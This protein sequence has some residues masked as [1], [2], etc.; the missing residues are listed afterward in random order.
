MKRRDPLA[1][2]V[3]E[4]KNSR[5]KARKQPNQKINSS[6]ANK[7]APIEPKID[8]R[9]FNRGHPGKAG[10]KPSAELKTI[11]D[12]KAKILEHGLEDV[13]VKGENGAKIVRK[14]R[15]LA[16]LDMLY[17]EA[18]KNKNIS[19]AR[20][21]IDRNL[22]KAAQPIKGDDETPLTIKVLDFSS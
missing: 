18:I 2:F 7:S 20:E 9:H 4:S 17:K 10:R 8:R 22:G 16:V 14:S 12:L 13:P 6:G 11:K 15:L 19:A 3:E 21:Y 1:D 5:S